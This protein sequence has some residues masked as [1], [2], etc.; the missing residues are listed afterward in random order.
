MT[1]AWFWIRSPAARAARPERRA[2]RARPERRAPPLARRPSA[3]LFGGSRL[4]GA[5]R[6]GR[7]PVRADQLE[8]RDLGPVA[9]AEAASEDARV[10]ALAIAEQSGPVLEQMPHGLRA[11]HVRGRLASGMEV[12][13]LGE[14]HQLLGHRP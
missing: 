6:R 9:R 5:G 12:S 3:R 4:A 1:R 13:A 14:R 10:A 8:V 2:A 7:A 11:P